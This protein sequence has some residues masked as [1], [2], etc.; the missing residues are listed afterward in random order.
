MLRV[1]DMESVVFIRIESVA[2]FGTRREAFQDVCGSNGAFFSSYMG[3]PNG[4]PRLPL[5]LLPSPG[6]MGAETSGEENGAYIRSIRR[7]R[8][9]HFRAFSRTASLFYTILFISYHDIY[10]RTC[11]SQSKPPHWPPGLKRH[12]YAA[13]AFFGSCSSKSCRSFE[14]H[15]IRSDDAYVSSNAVFQAG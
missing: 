8:R 5:V 12:G 4:C 10:Q 3:R 7:Q 13:S 6:S 14:D 1:S 2:A 9:F 15:K 11:N